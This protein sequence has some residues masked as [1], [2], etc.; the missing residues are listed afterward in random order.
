M[1]TLQKRWYH[2]VW[3]AQHYRKNSPLPNAIRKY[4][5]KAFEI[6][7]L[8]PASTLEELSQLEILWITLLHSH[9]RRFGYNATAGGDGGWGHTEETLKK[10]R[11]RK[12]WLGRRH[13][14]ETKLLMRNKRLGWVPSAETRQT[15]SKLRKGKPWTEARRNAQNR[16]KAG[17]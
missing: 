2:H 5:S 7:E 12:S 6:T 9:D 3:D 1:R 14:A 4:G 13:T 10:M 16:R 8:T 15:W 11:G 17:I